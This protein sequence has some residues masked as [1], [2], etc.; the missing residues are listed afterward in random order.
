MTPAERFDE[1][2]PGLCGSRTDSSAA[3]PIPRTRDAG[4][5]AGDA[6]TVVS[7][8]VDDGRIVAVD[9]QR[10]PEKLRSVRMRA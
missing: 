9:A 8:R 5:V 3:S 4:I 2:R 6:A 1:L 10:N 7:F